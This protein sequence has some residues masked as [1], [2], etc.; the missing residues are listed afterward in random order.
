MEEDYESY[1]CDIYI[2]FLAQI[3]TEIQSITANASLDEG[4]IIVLRS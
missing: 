1:A 2:F 4:E 3:W